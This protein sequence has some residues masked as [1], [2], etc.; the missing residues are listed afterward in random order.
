VPRPPS[1][2]PK[3][4][5]PPRDEA[6]LRDRASSLRGV[7]IDALALAMRF[8]IEGDAVRTKGR[9]GELLELALGASAGSASAPDFPHLGIELK[10]IPLDEMGRPRESTFVCALQVARASEEEWSKSS[11]RAK[12]AH[13]LWMP[14]VMP[15]KGGS[16]C[17]GNALFWRPTPSQEAVLRADFEELTG[18]IGIGKIEEVTGR[19]GRWLQ[20]RPKAAHGR[21]RTWAFGA[22]GERIATSPR[23]FYLRPSFTGAILRDPAA[24]P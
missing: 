5:A 20:V 18:M 24:E 3:A 6:E 15:P 4:L 12:L 16:R 22:E 17:I 8:D 23:G 14:I 2:A 13:V 19:I 11:V 9:V 21:V 10:T 7:S 1:E